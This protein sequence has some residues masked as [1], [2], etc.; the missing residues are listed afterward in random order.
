MLAFTYLAYIVFYEGLMLGGCAYL[1]FVEQASPWW[2]VLA[3]LLSAAAYKPRQWRY[4]RNR[5]K[6]QEMP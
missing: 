5:M 6:R 4:L 1:V 2:F 3:V